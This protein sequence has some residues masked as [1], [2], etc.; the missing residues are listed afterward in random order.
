MYSVISDTYFGE[1]P[2][3]TIQE[4]EEIICSHARWPILSKY[5]YYIF[6]RNNNTIYLLVKTLSISP[7]HI[8]SITAN[9]SVASIRS[10]NHF[11]NE[12]N[13]VPLNQIVWMSKLW[14]TFYLKWVPWIMGNRN[15]MVEG[16]NSSLL[17]SKWSV[18]MS[19]MSLF[20]NSNYYF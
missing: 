1:T 15:T 5:L 19:P 8:N 18:S 2:E 17:S 4:E 11:N 6:F 14:P 13:L 9:I 12:C 7:L 16:P 10:F 20:K 3:Q